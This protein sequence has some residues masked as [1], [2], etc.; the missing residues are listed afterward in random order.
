MVTLYSSLQQAID[1]YVL[2]NGYKEVDLL[3]ISAGNV[4][5]YGEL[6]LDFSNIKT[7]SDDDGYNLIASCTTADCTIVTT[8]RKYADVL[9]TKTSTGWSCE[10]DSRIYADCDILATT[11]GCT[12]RDE[13]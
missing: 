11:K 9:L 13:Q 5:D 4:T 2:A 10:C 6:D 8:P 7:P 1:L 12:V 3:L